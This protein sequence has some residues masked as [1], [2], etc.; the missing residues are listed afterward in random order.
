[1]VESK[2]NGW[3]DASQIGCF[4]TAHLGS[5]LVAEQGVSQSWSHHEDA[6][7]LA[8]GKRKGGMLTL[9]ASLYSVLCLQKY[10][11]HKRTDESKTLFH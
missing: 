5:T 8:Q 11:R 3:R 9:D 10:K 6:Q 2:S 7:S 4:V 1:M